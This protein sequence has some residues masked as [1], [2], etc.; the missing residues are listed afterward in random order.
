MKYCEG[1]SV[2][3]CQLPKLTTRV[4]F[5][6]LAPFFVFV[7]LVCFLSLA[8][9]GT[10]QVETKAAPVITAASSAQKGVYH[11]VRK[12]ETVW[13][14]AK[15][16]GIALEDLVK[17]NQISNDS[18]LDEG[19]MLFVPGALKLIDIY[20][21]PDDPNA[22]EFIWPARGKIIKYFGER[23]GEKISGGIEIQTA[24]DQDIVASRKGE[25]VFSDYLTGYQYTVI[26]DHKDG[27]Y[28][29]YGHNGKSLVEVG[30][31]V[32]KGQR[33]A[34]VGR[35]GPQTSLYFEIRKND[36]ADNPLYYLP[37]L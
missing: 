20:I 25:V 2:V 24:E 31:T 14:I 37:K 29:V 33:V 4:R 7:S 11:K 36:K 6:S 5:P 3:E 35:F 16:Y 32:F 13:R 9:C 1:N 12:G 21:P 17:A 26:L 34:Q 27:F 18:V 30:E 15:S 8:G 10:T 23:N 28:S 22:Q 19:K